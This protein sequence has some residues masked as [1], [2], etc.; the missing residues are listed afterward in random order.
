MPSHLRRDLSREA[1]DPSS[2]VDPS[3][4]WRRG[5]RR[6][7]VT[8]SA[9]LSLVIVLGLGGYATA[10]RLTS[11]RFSKENEIADD[12]PLVY[13]NAKGPDRAAV[14]AIHAVGNAGLRQ[15]NGIYVDYRQTV[16][17]SVD[18]WTAHFGPPSDCSHGT[19]T[20]KAAG[21]DEIWDDTQFEGWHCNDV[22]DQTVNLHVFISADTW[23]VGDV[24]GPLD[25]Q[26][27]EA[28]LAYT[29]PVGPVDPRF[30]VTDLEVVD[31]TDSDTVHGS[32]LWT[33]RAED[34]PLSSECTLDLLDADGTKVTSL[35]YWIVFAMEDQYLGPSDKA[36]TQAEMKRGGLDRD[37]M[38]DGHFH[39]GSWETS[40]VGAVDADITCEDRAEELKEE[41]EQ[42]ERESAD[43]TAQ[44][45]AQ[46]GFTCIE[47]EG[48]SDHVIVGEGGVWVG[49]TTAVD[50]WG[51]TR[52]DPATNEIVDEI[53]IA[54]HVE[55]MAIGEGY[56]WAVTEKS[57]EEAAL[58]R[59]DP[60]T[61]STESVSVRSAFVGDPLYGST[62]GDLDMAVGQGYAWVTG[63]EATL[64]RIDPETLEVD[65]VSLAP[66]LKADEDLGPPWVVAGDS[67]VFVI[68]AGSV[69]E[70][71]PST[72]RGL[73]TPDEIEINGRDVS[74]DQ[75]LI[76]VARQSPTGSNE[77]FSFD[78]GTG[79]TGTTPLGHG[80]P[81]R[82][83][84][85]EG[86][87][88]V[89]QADDENS[90]WLSRID[91]STGELM[92]DI[93][94]AASFDAGVGIGEGSAWLTG[95]GVVFR[96]TPE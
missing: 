40:A 58:V 57:D 36:W 67:G 86:M 22:S 7:W 73:G 8:R 68:Q 79:N 50:G 28:I 24:E 56:V 60:R 2:P 90:G 78:I 17:D 52:I 72:G 66:P 9:A 33:G 64:Q 43:A 1:R 63:P 5:R 65:T 44:T 54:G 14:F 61:G 71:D 41:Q 77:V 37:S 59:I 49:N 4:I 80:V 15:Q 93:E 45:C 29:E 88:W 69:Y 89:W 19:R 76:W 55:A 27:R 47:I 81:E 35:E 23:V 70:I 26:D 51:V 82:I 31:G 30:E 25:E 6:M 38:R 39:L 3:T 13:E 34:P 92:Q 10:D 53:R 42:E 83:A 91:P 94:A 12:A 20:T 48:M 74:L 84:A 11:D 62:V 32:F 87:V 16:R 96:V 85:G 21:D 95:D 46:D 18:S 75:G